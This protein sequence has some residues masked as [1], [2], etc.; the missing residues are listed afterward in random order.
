[1]GSYRFSFGAVLRV[2]LSG[3][4]LEARLG[5]QPSL[6]IHARAPDQFFYTVVDAQLDFERDASGQVVAVVLHQGGQDQ[7][8]LRVAR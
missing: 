3:R 7:R 8:A 6:P 5:D 1:M 4:Q 2:T